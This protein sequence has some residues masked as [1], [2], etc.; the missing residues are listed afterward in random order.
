VHRARLY[1]RALEGGR[2]TYAEVAAKFGVTRA[3]VCQYLTIVRRLPAD[4]V[5]AVE[6]E[7]APARLP[8]L[9]MKRLVG[10]ARLGTVEAQRAALI[11]ANR[12]RAR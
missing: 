11:S 10:I 8:T 5:A 1:E 2:R 7:V 9:S 12:V 6:A 4:A 3:A